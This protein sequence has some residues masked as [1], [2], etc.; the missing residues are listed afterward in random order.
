MLYRTGQ[1]PLEILKQLNNVRSGILGGPVRSVIMCG[2]VRSEWGAGKEWLAPND[3]KDL[4]VPLLHTLFPSSLRP[5][6]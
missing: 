2:P 6:T 4:S 5:T 3:V 1:G